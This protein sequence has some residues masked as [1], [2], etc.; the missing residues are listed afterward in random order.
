V[1]KELPQERARRLAMPYDEFK[2]RVRDAVLA[3]PEVQ[4][5]LSQ[6]GVAQAGSTE[7]RSSL[8]PQVNGFTDSG[9]RSVGQD[10]Y[11]GTPAYNRDGTNYGVSVRQVLFDFGAAYFGWQSGKAKERAAQEL[12]NSKRSEQAL[13]TVATVIDLERARAQLNLAKENVSSRL[14]IVR[15]VRERYELGGGSKPDIIRAEARY[16]EALALFTNSQNRLKAAEAAYRQAFAANPVGIIRGPNFEVPIEKID[17]TAEQLA[18]TFP[19]LQQL[20]QLRDAAD[21]DA[22]SARAKLMPSFNLAY[23][24][25]V[26]GVSAP[27]APS[28]TMDALVQLRYNF[29]TGGAETARKDAARFKA[30]QAEQDFQTGFRQFERVLTQTKAE[31]TNSDELVAARKVAA[32]A[33]ISSMR[34]VR[35][36]FAFNRG[37]LLD[38]LTVQENLFASGRDLVDA[39]ADR[40]ISRYRYMHLSAGLDRLFDL[41]EASFEVKGD[42]TP[43]NT[44]PRLPQRLGSQ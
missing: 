2:L 19:S 34:A 41:S 10:S 14:A 40:Q 37:T 3:Y 16:A 4:S 39:E 1:A 6:L 21:R 42:A 5:V 8:L 28:R 27:L 13:T 12:L 22:S 31:V 32:M 24:N 23:D 43:R 26:N 7:S 25:I 17:A 44:V 18:N 9:K 15:L 38:L 20:A 11:L 35:E 30:N 36:Q 29:Y 33:A